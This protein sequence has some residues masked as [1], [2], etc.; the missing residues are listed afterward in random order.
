MFINILRFKSTLLFFANFTDM[1]TRDGFLRMANQDHHL[2]YRRKSLLCMGIGLQK[3][4]GQGIQA[5]LKICLRKGK[6]F[7]LIV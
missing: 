7:K 1:K 6:G 4:V 2:E 5:I 3:E